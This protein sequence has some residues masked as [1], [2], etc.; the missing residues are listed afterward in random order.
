MFEQ[1]TRATIVIDK[2]GK[3]VY[4]R[5]TVKAWDKFESVVRA[6]LDKQ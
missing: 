3:I 4:W 1:T 6:E 5:T 2:Q